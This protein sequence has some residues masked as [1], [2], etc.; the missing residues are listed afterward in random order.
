MGTPVYDHTT[1]LTENS[2]SRT[3]K[4][5]GMIGKSFDWMIVEINPLKVNYR[6]LRKY[7]NQGSKMCR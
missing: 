2:R 6:V 5:M 7:L 3:E 1:S 4:E